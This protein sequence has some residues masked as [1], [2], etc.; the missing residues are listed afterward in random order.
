MLH[1]GQQITGV[2]SLICTMSNDSKQFR[3]KA[4]KSIR[5]ARKMQ[6]GSERESMMHVAAGYKHFAQ[7]EERSTGEAERSKT[8]PPSRKRKN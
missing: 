2:Q 6:P 8:R 5:R 3:D 7:I 1:L 4:A